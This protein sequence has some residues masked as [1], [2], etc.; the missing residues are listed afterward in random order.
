MNDQQLRALLLRL[1]DARSVTDINI[2]AGTALAEL[3]EE[4]EK[5]L[6]A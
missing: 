1:A 3:G 2:A 6:A 4:E 5:A